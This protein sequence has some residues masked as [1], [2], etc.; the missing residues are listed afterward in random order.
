MRLNTY[1]IC[2]LSACLLTS[3]FSGSS[4]LKRYDDTITGLE[5]YLEEYTENDYAYRG[6]LLTLEYLRSINFFDLKTPQITAVNH[7][8]DSIVVYWVGD[9]LAV[10]GIKVTDQGENFSAFIAITGDYFP[11]FKVFEQKQVDFVAIFYLPESAEFK[12]IGDGK[13]KVQLVLKDDSLS[14]EFDC[15]PPATQ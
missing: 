2:F 1:L 10:K 11:E 4:L 12:E 3:C 14:N 9:S 5:K 6:S 7:H 13:L 8:D 15:Y